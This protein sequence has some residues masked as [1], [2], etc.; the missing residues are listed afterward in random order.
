MKKVVWTDNNN[1]FV[2]RKGKTSNKKISDGSQLVQ[3]YTF[4]RAQWWLANSGKKF[5]MKEF[6]KLDVTNCMD[7]PYS[8]NQG[9]GGCYTHKF[10]QYIGIS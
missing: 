9:E 4:S 10:N 3:T 1:I 7:C 8:G 5:T 2:V 6:F